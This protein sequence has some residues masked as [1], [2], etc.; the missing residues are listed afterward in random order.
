MDRRRRKPD[1]RNI[2]VPAGGTPRSRRH[3]L[4]EISTPSLRNCCSEQQRSCKVFFVAGHHSTPWST[5][6]LKLRRPKYK[7][8]TQWWIFM[9]TQRNFDSNLIDAFSV[10]PK[11]KSNICCFG[12]GYRLTWWSPREKK[13]P[14]LFQNK[15]IIACARPTA[16]S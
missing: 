14:K 3:L 13:F 16:S 15:H 11:A 8:K 6:R 10:V 2:V 9:N 4:K 7:L 5:V 12:I 1:S